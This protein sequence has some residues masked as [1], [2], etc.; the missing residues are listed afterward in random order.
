MWASKAV[1][2][3]SSQTTQKPGALWRNVWSDRFRASRWRR[4][5]S[6][7][8]RLTVLNTS[9]DLQVGE[10]V[11]F[12]IIMSWNPSI[13]NLASG[14]ISRSS[15]GVDPGSILAIGMSLLK[16]QRPNTSGEMDKSKSIMG[17][18]H[19]LDLRTMHPNRRTLSQAG[20]NYY[21]CAL[22]S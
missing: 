5:T 8:R 6:G 16:A 17:S 15:Q 11:R 20:H 1:S 19:L 4:S 18:Q 2:T 10:A 14:S 12:S 9:F 22:P 13:P 7:A 21:H 3:L